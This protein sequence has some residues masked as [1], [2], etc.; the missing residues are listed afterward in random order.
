MSN[1]VCGVGNSNFEHAEVRFDS[2]G[3]ITLLCGAMDHG[4]GHQTAFRQ[5]LA[6]RLGVDPDRIRYRFG[7]T[8]QVTAGMGTFGARSAILAGSAIAVAADKIIEKGKSIAA[9]LLEAGAHDIEYRDGT[10]AV[11]GTDRTVDLDTVAGA[12]FQ[13]NKLPPGVSPGLYERGDFASNAG[14]T[15]PNGAHLAEVEIDADT[16]KVSLVGYWCV[17]DAG[18]ILNPCCSTAR[19]TAASRRAPAK[20]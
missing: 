1:T 14:A 10:F 8:D 18:T 13:H 4:Q 11:S 20:F 3:G 19:F 5:I 9:H 2:G 6:D 12:A 17:D 15:F 7:D 16:G